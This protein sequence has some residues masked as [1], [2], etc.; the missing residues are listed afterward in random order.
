MKVFRSVI[1]E[2]PLTEVWDAVRAF[3]GVAD[4]NPGVTAAR[5]ETGGPTSVGSVR[6]LDIMDGTYFRETL[7]A[8]SD[9]EH[10]YSYDIIASPL[11]CSHHLPTH[12]DIPGADGNKP[13]G[14]RRGRCAC[15]PDDEAG[16]EAV[17]GDQIYRDGMR[18]LNDYLTGMR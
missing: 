16:L 18:G 6:R 14:I 11:A 2:A 8:H 12:R 1:L 5:M 13:R 17:V 3:D 7:L 10:F 9:L 15:A 4:W